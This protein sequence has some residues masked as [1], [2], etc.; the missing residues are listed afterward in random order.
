[1][2]GVVASVGGAVGASA[3]G[4]AAAASTA[5][6]Q[7]AIYEREAGALRREI[8]GLTSEQLASHPIPGTWS[9]GQ[10]VTHLCDAE[11]AFSDRIKRIVAEDPKPILQAW[12]ENKWMQNL[13]VERGPAE[14]SAHLVEL[15]RGQ[16]VWILREQGPAV[17]RKTGVHSQAGELTLLQILEK[18]NWHLEHHLQFLRNK[19]QL[20]LAAKR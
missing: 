15:V 16:I 20:V 10:I 19:R 1:M 18:A 17:Y 9:I 14:E 3:A 8:S 6:E 2:A 12:D 4:S 7:L 11:Q 13:P 5:S